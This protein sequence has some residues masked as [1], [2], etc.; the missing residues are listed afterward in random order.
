MKW[1]I[2]DITFDI[3]FN[4]IMEIDSNKNRRLAKQRKIGL[5][6]ADYV[7]RLNI[8]GSTLLSKVKIL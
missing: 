5:N 4:F 6:F 8:F 2:F 3:F 1:I 7:F